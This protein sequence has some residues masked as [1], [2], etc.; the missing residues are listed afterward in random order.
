MQQG[1]GSLNIRRLLFIKEARYLKELHAFL[2]KGRCKCLGSLQSFLSHASQRC[3]V[4]IRPLDTDILSS[5]LTAHQTD[6]VV[7][8][9]QVA[10]HCSS[11]AQKF[12]FG[13]QVSRMAV[14]YLF[15]EMAGDTPFR[16]EHL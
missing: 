11:R 2:C 10:Q 12:T 16:T 3:G 1:A 8:G 14:T 13:G 7:D 15:I 5:L 9:W 6:G 4:S